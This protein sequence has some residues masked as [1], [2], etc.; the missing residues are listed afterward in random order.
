MVVVIIGAMDAVGVVGDVLVLGHCYLLPLVIAE[1]C[2][3][4]FVVKVVQGAF[5]FLQYA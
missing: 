2:A 3:I 1:R 5:E 4:D